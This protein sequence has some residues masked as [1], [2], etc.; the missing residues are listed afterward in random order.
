MQAKHHCQEAVTIGTDIL[1]HPNLEKIYVVI[2]GEDKA[3]SL[4]NAFIDI[5]TGLGYVIAKHSDKLTIFAD[6]K[7]LSLI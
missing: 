1:E 4:K 7:A 5:T 3:L 6:A 2:S